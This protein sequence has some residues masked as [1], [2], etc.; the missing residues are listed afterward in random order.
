MRAF[1]DIA[2]MTV[3]IAVP[4][5]VFIARAADVF[6]CRHECRCAF[7]AAAHLENSIHFGVIAG[8]RLFTN[9]FNNR[10]ELLVVRKKRRQRATIRKEFLN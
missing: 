4:G 10:C 9:C 6:G 2:A 1:N 7:N 5:R 3:L 8:G